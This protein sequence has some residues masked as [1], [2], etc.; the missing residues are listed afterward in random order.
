MAISRA[1]LRSHIIEAMKDINS[2]ERLADGREISRDWC[3]EGQGIDG[4]GEYGYR[5]FPPKLLIRRAFFHV[6]GVEHINE[7][8]AD[9][10]RDYLKTQG[11]FV[12]MHGNA[13]HY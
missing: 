2:G 5:H 9:S 6:A 11:F 8:T 1:I 10:A 13:P 7:Y 3:V 12:V 4:L